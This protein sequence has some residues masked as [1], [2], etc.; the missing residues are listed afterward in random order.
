MKYSI[1]VDILLQDLPICRV[2]FFLQRKTICSSLKNELICRFSCL[3]AQ[4]TQNMLVLFLILAPVEASVDWS[5]SKVP[6]L[7]VL[8]FSAIFT[9]DSFTFGEKNTL[10]YPLCFVHTLFL[11]STNSNQR[12]SGELILPKGKQATWSYPQRFW[13]D[14]NNHVNATLFGDASLFRQCA[15]PIFVLLEFKTANVIVLF[16]S[17]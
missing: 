4:H 7:R 16:R 3:F 14:E 8:R 12:S 10:K 15:S 11:S 2:V 1:F 6:L 5:P 13:V 17:I 9:N